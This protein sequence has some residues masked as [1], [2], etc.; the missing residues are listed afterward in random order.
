MKLALLL[1]FI[2]LPAMADPSYTIT[3]PDN[4]GIIVQGQKGGVNWTCTFDEVV[5]MRRCSRTIPAGDGCNTCTVDE[6]GNGVCTAMGCI[7]ASPVD[8]KCQP[9][10]GE[11][12]VCQEKP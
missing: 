8:P 11:T 6:Q 3:A 7:K 5:Q 2:A 4:H 12:I 10:K 1:A 9:K